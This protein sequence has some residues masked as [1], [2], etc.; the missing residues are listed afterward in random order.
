[1]STQSS[2]RAAVGASSNTL[3]HG[4]ATT[5]PH[6][7]PPT[8]SATLNEQSKTSTVDILDALDP[9]FRTKMRVTIE[10]LQLVEDILASKP[11]ELRQQE[12]TR[13]MSVPCIL[14]KT[15]RIEL[16]S[17]FKDPEDYLQD[18]TEW[19][20]EAD[21]ANLDTTPPALNPDVEPDA[22]QRL[23][24][25][26][27]IMARCPVMPGRPH[28]SDVHLVPSDQLMEDLDLD[29]SDSSKSTEDHDTV[30]D[31]DAAQ[32]DAAGKSEAHDCKDVTLKHAWKKPS[33]NVLALLDPR[34]DKG[35]NNDHDAMPKNPN[36]KPISSAARYYSDASGVKSSFLPLIE[37]RRLA[38]TGDNT[39][40]ELDYWYKFAV[41]VYYACDVPRFLWDLTDDYTIGNDEAQD[42]RFGHQ[43][44]AAPALKDDEPKKP[45]WKGYTDEEWAEIDP[46]HTGQDDCRLC[47]GQCT[48]PPMSE[49]DKQAAQKA[50]NDGMPIPS[51]PSLHTTAPPSQLDPAVELYGHP[52]ELPKIDPTTPTSHH[53]E[54]EDL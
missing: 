17:Y 44:T 30:M 10:T 40:D 24:D 1:M 31:D 33:Q 50:W 21:I 16:R 11:N 45:I 22:V 18:T 14:V 38:I 19:Y 35:H 15:L 3:S 51:P 29:T 26:L 41:K 39:V 8:S 4:P 7:N 9:S 32:S 23:H 27:R 20:D 47:P 49:E 36:P 6:G 46:S 13:F 2:T 43:P 48:D 53:T 12:A 37:T 28:V 5:S 34:D 42:Y 52:L 54:E 25:R